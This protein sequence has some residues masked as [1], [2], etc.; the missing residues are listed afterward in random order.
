MYCLPGGL[1]PRAAAVKKLS[2]GEALTTSEEARDRLPWLLAE[3]AW[4][5]SCSF[6]LL[7][8]PAINAKV[9]GQAVGVCEVQA[10]RAFV[11]CFH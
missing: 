4:L 8:K 5:A 1:R 6:V 11:H 10:Q 3:P 9:A 7:C 2:G